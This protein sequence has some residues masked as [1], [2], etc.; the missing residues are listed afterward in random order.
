MDT[1]NY[2][3]TLLSAQVIQKISHVLDYRC[4]VAGGQQHFLLGMG[5]CQIYLWDGGMPMRWK[6]LE[7][8]KTELPRDTLLQV[9][10][11]QELKGE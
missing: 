6:K 5:K 8:F 4:M 7:N 2:K 10:I 1:F 3:P 9:E 11:I